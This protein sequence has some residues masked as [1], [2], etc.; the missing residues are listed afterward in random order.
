MKHFTFA[1]VA[2]VCGGVLSD[3]SIQNKVV[4]NVA[5]DNRKV[6]HGGLFVAIIGERLD[7]HAFIPAAFEAGALCAVS[8]RAV[9]FP[10]IRVKDTLTALGSIAR[11]YM[12][13]F[14]I[15]VIGVTGSVGKTTSKELIASVLGE[16]YVVHKTFGNLNNQTGVPLTVFS[17]PDDAQAAVIEMGMNHAGEIDALAEIVKPS[18]CV[19]TNIGEAHIENLGS[20]QNIFSAK[21]EML[22]HMKQGGRIV[23]DGED[24]F[25]RALC[26]TRSDV[27][28]AGFCDCDVSATDI[29]ELGFK[30]VNFSI[31]HRASRVN[32]TMCVPGIHMVK[33][34]LIATAVGIAL[35]MNLQEIANGI[36][37]FTPSKGRMNIFEFNGMTVIDDSYNANPTSMK[38]AIETL[39][40]ATGRRVCIIGDML[41]LGQN[42]PAYHKQIGDYARECGIDQVLCVGELSKNMLLNNPDALHFDDVSALEQELDNILKPGDT[43]L[44]KASNGTGLH[45]LIGGY[46]NV[47]T[48]S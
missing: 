47:S 14:D 26:E 2:R 36:E 28:T 27:I 45:K 3:I 20:K 4:A 42:A 11:Y 35:G 46:F 8:D 10:H 33:N 5:I 39:V 30:G 17:M 43:V 29:N 18:V 19:I 15:P 31:N 7:G 40:S 6:M 16:K 48:L 24:P 1:D 37:K 9:D 32:V 23:V 34:A 21:C 25:L 44:I 22:A 38:A 12:S 13:L 41:E